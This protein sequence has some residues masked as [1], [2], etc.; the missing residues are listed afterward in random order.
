MNKRNLTILTEII[1]HPD[2][3]IKSSVLEK[4]LGLTRRQLSYSLKQINYELTNDSY[5]AIARTQSGTL[6]AR[7]DML[8]FLT[9]QSQKISGH[10]IYHDEKQRFLM[11]ILYILTSDT[12]LSLTHIYDFLEVS[13]TTT[14]N[15][16]KNVKSFLTRNK[17]SLKYNRQDGYFIQGNE[18]KQRFLINKLTSS[19]MRYTDSKSLISRLSKISVDE[20]IHFIRQVEEKIGV[21]YS[22]EAFNYL[23]YTSLMN[24]ARNQSGKIKNSNYFFNQISDTREY[25]IISELVYPD[26]ISCKSDIEW[27]SIIFLSANTIRGDFFLPDAS[28][29]HAVESMISSF[30]QQTLVE[31]ADRQSFEKRLLAHLRPAIYR[32][33]YG[34]HLN[35]IGI[36]KIMNNEPRQKIL[37]STIRKIIL[38]LEQL[39]G[40]KFP[41]NEINLIAFYFGSDLEN[42]QSSIFIK[43]RAAVVCANGVIAAKLMFEN[44]VHLFPEITFL[45]A[46]SVREF[47][48][49]SKDYDLVF[50]TVPLHTNARQYII[51]PVMQSE[52]AIQLRYRVLNDLGMTNAEVTVNSLM[53]IIKKHSN[54]IDTEG[55]ESDLC[56]WLSSKP[57]KTDVVKQL[58]NL[59]SYIQ[60]NFVQLTDKSL[61]WRQAICLATE[62]LLK[63]KI[64]TNQYLKSILQNTE[65]ENNYSFLGSKL[66]IPHTTPNNGIIG[67]GFGFLVLKKPV[68]FPTGE[69]ISVIV[70]IAVKDTTKHLKAIKQLTNLASSV[71]L[72]NRIVSTSNTKTIYQYIK[73]Q[74]KGEQ[75]DLS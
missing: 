43:E 31:I 7:K 50:T 71:G 18:L 21:I 75:I 2:L 72:I 61:D 11:I 51:H 60:P 5:N 54:S 22:D 27:L 66:A 58:P 17:L 74:M 55:L 67:D 34:L 57:I 65:S 23:I 25:K 69:N 36:T 26:W 44:L 20:I 62:P 30:E 8:E 14:A 63:E 10:Y 64:V 35:D 73:K 47:E 12:E 53:K 48:A 37:V 29:V 56:Q 42:K 70:P 52:T 68:I 40:K 16:L 9:N 24:I 41:E 45:S 3:K 6:I 28:I 32:V 33:K 13:K 59:L 15:D 19:L 1:R 38:P 4:E 49:F 39:V 46:T